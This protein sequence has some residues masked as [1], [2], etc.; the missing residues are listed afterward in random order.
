MSAQRVVRRVQVTG[1]STFIVSIPKEWASNIGI[2][3]GSM[4]TL[5]LEHDGSIR[6]IPSGRK[7]QIANVA[8]IFVGRDTTH[9]A[10]LR[11]VMSKYLVGYKTIHLKFQHDDPALRSKL[12]EIAVKKLIGAEVLHED[13]HE[14]TIQVLVNVEDLPISNIILKMKD[15]GKSMLL[16]AIEACRQSSRSTISMEELVTRDDIMDKLY[17]Y[18]LRQLNT[19]L[20]GYVALEEIGL[21]RSEEILSYGM[22]LK[23]MERIGDHA[24]TIAL[25]LKEIPAGFKGLQNILSYGEMTTSFFEDS[26]RIF[27]ERNKRQANDLLDI[28]VEEIKEFEKKLSSV[29]NVEDAKLLTIIRTII[30]SYRRVADYST[31]ILEAT[32]DLH[33]LS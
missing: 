18:G 25:N 13:S 16:D 30:G 29:Y 14:M 23:N 8:E 7:P 21:S 17:L 3:R 10:V 31:D 6:V 33:D 28:K 24:A 12:K 1:G 20:K 2:D 5:T 15:T 26:V 22:V 19:A 32:I 4:V 9:G 11:D 27:L